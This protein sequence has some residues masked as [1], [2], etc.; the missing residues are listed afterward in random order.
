MS[1]LS[2]LLDL[3][4]SFLDYKSKSET[5]DAVKEQARASLEV[6]D[7]QVSVKK[8]EIEAQ[9]FFQS[10]ENQAALLKVSAD[11]RKLLEDQQQSVYNNGQEFVREG[12]TISP[13]LLLAIAAGIWLAKRNKLI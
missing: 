11:A 3:G 7:K 6:V 10:P 2:G 4:G 12:K 9:A 1:F 13:V 8:A 5:A